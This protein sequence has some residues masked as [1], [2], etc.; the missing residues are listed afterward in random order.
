MI[1]RAARI[2]DLPEPELPLPPLR[3]TARMSRPA[4]AAQAVAA[5]RDFMARPGRAGMDFSISLSFRISSH[6]GRDAETR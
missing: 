5:M 6:C 4:A 2:L 3:A 1:A